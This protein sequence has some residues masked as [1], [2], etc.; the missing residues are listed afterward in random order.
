MPTVGDVSQ[1]LMFP[2]HQNT[3]LRTSLTFT[4][5][6]KTET[7]AFTSSSCLDSADLDA[8]LRDAQV[9]IANQEVFS[10]LVAEAGH[11]STA[12]VQV[13]ERLIIINAAQGLDLT[14]ELV[15]YFSDF[16]E[17]RSN[18]TCI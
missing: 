5:E 2:F 3:R 11:L 17:Q 7:S 9:E 16:T 1:Q 12:S 6:S 8:A 4:N 13:A 18:P 15:N 14:F 10:L